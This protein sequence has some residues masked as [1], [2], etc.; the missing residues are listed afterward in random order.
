MK[1]FLKEFLLRGLICAAGG[2]LVLAIIYGIL[3]A[4]GAVVSFSP[5]EVCL[6]ILTITLLAF[7]AA[8]MTAIYQMEQLPLPTMILLHGGALYIAY[9]L[10]YLING[11]L[12]NQ[13]MPILVFTGIFVVGY[14]LIW[15][16]IY[17]I[18]KKKTAKLNE[19]LNKE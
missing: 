16:I 4:T 13:L 17:C 14:A 11:W 12:A 7:I 18:E 15:L 5:R 10:T 6:G 9:I 19:L 1:K 2:P 8:G 3:G